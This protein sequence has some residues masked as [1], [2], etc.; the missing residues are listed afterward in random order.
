MERS[1]VEKEALGQRSSSARSLYAIHPL[2]ATPALHTAS[3]MSTTTS[4]ALAILPT[5]PL[6]ADTTTHLDLVGVDLGRHFV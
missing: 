4:L 6:R 1:V 5:F 2:P 3:P